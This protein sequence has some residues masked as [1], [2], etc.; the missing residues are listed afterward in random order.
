MKVVWPSAPEVIEKGILAD[1]HIAKPARLVT[2]LTRL[3]LMKSGK[4]FRS[5]LNIKEF[6]NFLLKENKNNEFEKFC[7]QSGSWIVS[8]TWAF[9]TGKGSGSKINSD[10]CA[11]LTERGNVLPKVLAAEVAKRSSDLMLL[12]MLWISRVNSEN[13]ASQKNCRERTLGFFTAIVWFSSN[14]KEI[15]KCAKRLANAL[16][17]EIEVENNI[18]DFF[19]SV[20]FNSLFYDKNSLLMP[21][22]E[23]QEVRDALASMI[24]KNMGSGEIWKQDWWDQVKDPEQDIVK[25]FNDWIYADDRSVAQKAW[26][27]FFRAIYKDKRFLLYAQRRF[28]KA[29]FDWFDPIL[30]DQTQ[31]KNRPWDYDHILPHSWTHHRTGRTINDVPRLVKTWV[32]SNGNFRV[33]PYELNRSKG[34][35]FL[36]EK[37]LPTYNLNEKE[38]IEASFVSDIAAWDSIE[39]LKN[40]KFIEKNGSKVQQLFVTAAVNRTVD[41]YQEWY[42]QLHVRELMEEVE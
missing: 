17:K 14:A 23:P 10:K 12:I 9:L 2:V 31:D 40:G 41:I 38:V 24:L 15:G 32:N 36:F 33:W 30:P 28:I 34:N 26:L 8:N 1:C 13:V 20:R 6:G 22:P 37:E 39:E 29:Q 35:Q 27:N 7:E 21:L 5:E 42:E 4:S 19:D 16:Q 3:Y 11:F 18:T 25:Y